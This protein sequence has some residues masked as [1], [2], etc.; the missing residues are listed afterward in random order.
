[1]PHRR[2]SREVGSLPIFISPIRQRNIHPTRFVRTSKILIH[3]AFNTRHI[4][5][6][7]IASHDAITHVLVV[8]FDATRG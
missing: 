6:H 4:A 2:M 8:R 3:A 5:E 7:H 1:M